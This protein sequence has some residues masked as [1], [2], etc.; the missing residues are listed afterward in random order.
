MSKNKDREKFIDDLLDDMDNPIVSETGAYNYLGF[1]ESLIM[2]SNENCTDKERLVNS[3]DTMRKNEMDALVVHL[4]DNQIYR[5]CRDQ[6][7]QMCRQGV[8]K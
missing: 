6:F 4:K 3:L 8:F 5:D 2:S 1:V 7:K